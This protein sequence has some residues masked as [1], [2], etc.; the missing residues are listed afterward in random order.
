MKTNYVAVND[1]L[2]LMLVD[3]VHSP[4]KMPFMHLN[5]TSDFPFFFR[6]AS[7]G[8]FRAREKEKL[9]VRGP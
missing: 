7:H 9:P 5:I 2:I 1:V 8:V 4:Y 6:K 3:V